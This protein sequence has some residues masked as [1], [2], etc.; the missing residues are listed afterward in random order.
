[1]P[2][3]AKRKDPGNGSGA[4]TKKK[5][6]QEALPSVDPD[7]LAMAHMKAFEKWFLESTIIS[8]IWICHFWVTACFFVW[9]QPILVM[10][11]LSHPRHESLNGKNYDEFLTEQL[12]NKDYDLLL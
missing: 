3:K 7:T 10:V 8:L 5:K 4:A 11:P 2:P 9:L 12:G 1:M 6:G